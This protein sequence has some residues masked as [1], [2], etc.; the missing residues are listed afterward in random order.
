MTTHVEAG[1]SDEG[2]ADSVRIR[3]VDPRGVP[4]LANRGDRF[5]ADGSGGTADRPIGRLRHTAAFGQLRE[6]IHFR[7]I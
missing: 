5:L 1:G 6:A 7:R 4:G 3:H 2:A